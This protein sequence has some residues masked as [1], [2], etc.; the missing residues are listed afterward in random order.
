M[1]NHLYQCTYDILRSDIPEAAKLPASQCYKAK[2]VRLY[3]RQL[4]K[5]MLDN[6]GQDKLDS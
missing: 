6:T 5:V 1:E 4:E 3:A 2:I